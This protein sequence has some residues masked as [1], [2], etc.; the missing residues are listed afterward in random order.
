MTRFERERATI[1]YMN[2]VRKNYWLLKR[3]GGKGAQAR[4]SERYRLLADWLEAIENTYRALRRR[5][6]KSAAR[7]KHDWLVA[8]TLELMVFDG[9]DREKIRQALSWPRP[10]TE[11][12]VDAL[13]EDVIRAIEEKA[14]EA[15]LLG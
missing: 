8:R 11:Q 7:M 4:R 15:G 3:K 5:E 12:Y 14:Q 1:Q 6:G 13:V 9:A 10:V 2:K